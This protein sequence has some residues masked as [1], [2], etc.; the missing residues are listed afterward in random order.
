MSAARF[1]SLAGVDTHQLGQLEEVGHAACFFQVLIQ[2]VA[3]AGNSDVLPELLAQRT[4]FTN[5]SIEAPSRS[6]HAARLPYNFAKRAME[7][8]DGPLASDGE[9]FI[10]RFPDSVDGVLYLLPRFIDCCESICRE[11]I[12]HGVGNDEV[13]I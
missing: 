2:V 6:C 1:A 5:G 3:A 7:R 12:P 9:Q 10:D 13:T 4:D 11:I 8:I